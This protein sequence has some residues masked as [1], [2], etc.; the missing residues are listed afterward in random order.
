[1]IIIILLLSLLL[2]FLA[3]YTLNLQGT[4][5][6][7]GR[8]L[9]NKSQ[10]V[11]GAGV[12]DAITPKAQTVRNV[13][14]FVL[15]ILIFILTTYAYA[16]YHALWVLFACYISSHIITPIMGI[17][18]GSPRLV[19]AIKLDMRRRH[20]NYLK[21]GDNFRA[22]AIKALIN[23]IDKLSLEDILNEIR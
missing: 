3:A 14:I 13:A 23:K 7:L 2:S 18:A 8:L 12:Q 6:A 5:L 1:M 4:T 19:N 11:P 20:T 21:S 17:K 10:N 22:Q 16:W 15:I 9:V